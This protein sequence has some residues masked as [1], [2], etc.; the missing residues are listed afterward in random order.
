MELHNNLRASC[1]VLSDSH[2][3]IPALKAALAWAAQQ[4]DDLAVA[5]FLGD[6][7]DDLAAASAETGFSLPWHAVRGNGDMDDSLPAGLTISLGHKGRALFLAHGNR[8]R[9]D[10]GFEGITAAARLSGAEAALFG[11]THIPYCG[12]FDGIFLL[13]PGSIG[14]PRS[15]AGPSFAILD[16]PVS[17]PLAA[18][19]YG[20][21]QQGRNYTVRELEL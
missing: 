20:L 17:G 12:L 16:C 15:R 3:N 11:H 8:Y 4:G 7:A 2:G 19:F 18:R 14:R 21:F 5:L 13:N 9:L 10:E 6:G 1:L